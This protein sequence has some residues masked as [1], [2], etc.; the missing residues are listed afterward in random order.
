MEERSKN[1][2]VDFIYMNQLKGRDFQIKTVTWHCILI[3]DR[4]KLCHLVNLYKRINHK[5]YNNKEESIS[6][7]QS[8]S[9]KYF[10]K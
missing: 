2:S 10:Q 8:N 4:L 3:Y 7:Y 5:K 6:E 1:E 9:F